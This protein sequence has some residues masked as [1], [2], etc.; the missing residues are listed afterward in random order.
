MSPILMGM[1][2]EELYCLVNEHPIYMVLDAAQ[3]KATVER[4]L[5]QIY[6]GLPPGSDDDRLPDVL[7]Y[8]GTELQAVESAPDEVYARAQLAKAVDVAMAILAGRYSGDDRKF[9]DAGI[10]LLRLSLCSKAA[11]GF[12]KMGSGIR[13][14]ANADWRRLADIYEMETRAVGGRLAN[15]VA[16]TAFPAEMASPLSDLAARAVAGAD[17]GMIH[18]EAEAMVQRHRFHPVPFGAQ[19]E[20]GE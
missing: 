14:R 6:A 10:H 1:S 12:R 19:P 13:R 9:Y 20:A 4:K 17:Y 3:W 7:A 11:S 16:D 2:I 18:E 5:G 15:L 8:M